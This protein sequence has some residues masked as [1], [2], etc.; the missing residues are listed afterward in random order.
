MDT[1]RELIAWAPDQRCRCDI[2]DRAIPPREPVLGQRRNGSDTSDAAVSGCRH[3]TKGSAIISAQ[4][5]ATEWLAKATIA[6]S[7][8]EKNIPWPEWST[9]DTLAVAVLLHDTTTLAALDFTEVEA[10]QR[11]RHDIGSP[12]LDAATRWFA[13]LC[14]RLQPTAT[15]PSNRLHA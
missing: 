8:N 4:R 9:G 10:L 14:A 2:F 13:I 3:T 15:R 1:I 6:R 7:C 12:D 11:L 5:Y